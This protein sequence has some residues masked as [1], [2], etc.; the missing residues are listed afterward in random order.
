[1]SKIKNNRNISAL[2]A[3]RRAFALLLAFILAAG[4]S[5]AVFAE[6]AAA[7]EHIPYDDRVSVDQCPGH[8]LYVDPIFFGTCSATGLG[9]QFCEHCQ[10]YKFGVVLPIDPDFHLDK[11]LSDKLYTQATC[12]EPQYS[13]QICSDCG[14]VVNKTAIGAPDPSAH[15]S[16]G[17]WY[18]VTPAT[19]I[20]DGIKA[21][22]CSLCGAY[23]N[24]T[25]EPAGDTHHI[26]APDAEWEVFSEPNCTEPGVNV[27]YCIYCGEIAEREEIP[28]VPDAHIFSED[29]ITDRPAT[30][31]ETGSRS[32]HCTV[33]GART[34]IGEIPVD[35]NG[36]SFTQKYYVVK[37]STCSTTGT[38]AVKC[39]YCGEYGESRVIPPDPTAHVWDEWIIDKAATCTEGGMRHRICKYCGTVSVKEATAPTQHTWTDYE[40]VSVSEDKKSQLI[41]YT[42]A[43]CGEKMRQI[44][45]MGEETIIPQLKL[46]DGSEYVIDEATGYITGV[47]ASTDV[48]TLM[49]NFVSMTGFSVRD[50]GGAAYDSYEA[51]VGTGATLRGSNDYG[52]VV[53]TVTVRGDVN[54]DG[55]VLADDARR[56][57]RASARL[58]TLENEYF[59]AADQ[60]LDGELSADD[61][62]KILRRSAGL[63]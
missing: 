57:L 24:Y 35:P 1:M 23:F 52:S 41:E 9:N 43:V 4:V 26:A 56:V 14:L 40:V 7:P 18:D 60:N 37:D 47:A 49:S 2:G 20:S 33:C 58:D 63:E 29:Y 48:R 6:D 34:D 8:E 32:K 59:I 27:K 19:C 53:Y 51:V 61:A 3:A 17:Q 5:G 39:V 13:Y 10:Y 12:V 25:A 31:V 42:C 46:V 54:G 22:K 15:I 38:E 11:H 45:P 44:R 55:R 30:C 28:S 16:D 50:S 62:R 36:H 21:N